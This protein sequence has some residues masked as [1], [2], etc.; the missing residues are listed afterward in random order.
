MQSQY[1]SQSVSN[2]SQ[3]VTEVSQVNLDS[4]LAT[5]KFNGNLDDVI[6]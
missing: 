5:M 4:Q 6:V 3:S 2:V 1:Q